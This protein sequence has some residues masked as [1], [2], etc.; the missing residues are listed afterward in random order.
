MGH[1]LRLTGVLI[2]G[3]VNPQEDTVGILPLPT[4]QKFPRVGKT[5]KIFYNEKDIFTRISKQGSEYL[6]GSTTTALPWISVFD[7]VGQGNKVA[8]ITLG[9]TPLKV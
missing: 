7:A 9:I 4:R 2:G 8:H 1:H 6:A 3:E 5:G